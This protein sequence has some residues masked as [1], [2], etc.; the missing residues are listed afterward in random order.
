MGN[1]LVQPIFFSQFEVFRKGSSGVNPVQAAV[2]RT[3]VAMGYELVDLEIAGRGLLRVFID[4][5]VDAPAAVP[6]ADAPPETRMFESAIRMEDCERV[7][8]QLTHVLT[9]ENIDYA[10]LEVSSPG[11][12][13]PLNREADYQ[14]FVG[15]E[16]ALRLRV[17]LSG[18]RN[19]SGVL[20]RDEA[21]AHGWWL[22]LIDTAAQEAGAKRKP[23]AKSVA[24]SAKAKAKPLPEAGAE[25]VKRLSF[26]L[27]DV[28][29]ARL[30]PKV[31]F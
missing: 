27:A 7:S 31:K 4:L 13:R 30:V 28:E 10:R 9:V 1:G 25:T 18:R 23:G 12:D 17:P 6:Q 22:E 24:K 3:V 14:R 21:T 2:E 16:V 5:P 20:W 15:Y 19:F 26:E 8:H 11:L 29:R